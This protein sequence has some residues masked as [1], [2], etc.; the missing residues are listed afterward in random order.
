MLNVSDFA[1]AIFLKSWQKNLPLKYA[2]TV[3]NFVRKDSNIFRAACTCIVSFTD[4][5]KRKIPLFK[6]PLL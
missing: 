5:N 3:S 1:E 6:I 4:E 2:L